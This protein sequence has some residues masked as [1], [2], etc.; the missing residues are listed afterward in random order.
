MYF[1]LAPWFVMAD[2]DEEQNWP[3]FFENNR[4]IPVHPNRRKSASQAKPNVPFCLLF[5]SVIGISL[6]QAVVS[7]QI[8]SYLT[9]SY[10]YHNRLYFDVLRNAS[11]SSM[12]VHT[13]LLMLSL[14]DT[15]RYI[16]IKFMTFLFRLIGEKLI[17]NFT[18]IA[19]IG[20]NACQSSGPEQSGK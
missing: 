18:H 6:P 15:K 16:C 17:I 7:T 1:K 14:Q 11:F 10:S 9:C 2:E 8:N 4:L 12:I 3:E 13:R 5:K 20:E 19:N